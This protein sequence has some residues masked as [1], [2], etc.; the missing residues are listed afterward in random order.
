MAHILKNKDLE[1]H[2]DLPLEKYNFS[3]FDWTGKIV[4]MK[5]QNIQM[6]GIESTDFVNENYFGRGFYNEFG[7]ETAIGFDETNI[8]GWFHKIGVGLLKKEDSKYHFFKKYEVKPAEFEI[9]S[10]PNSL[11][12]NCKSKNVNGYSYFLRKEIEIQTSGFIITV[13]L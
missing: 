12:I 13:R 5:F 3:R 9:I 6:S 4:E 11:I 7:I 8:G 1:I 10:E 2:V